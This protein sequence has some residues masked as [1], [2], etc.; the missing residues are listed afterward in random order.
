M[1]KKMDFAKN[2]NHDAHKFCCFLVHIDRILSTKLGDLAY[3]ARVIYLKLKKT[4][5]SY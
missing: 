2:R 3:D 4:I 5:G 1:F